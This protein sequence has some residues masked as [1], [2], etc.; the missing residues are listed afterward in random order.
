MDQEQKEVN[1]VEPIENLCG[2]CKKPKTGDTPDKLCQ[3][4]RPTNDELWRQAI[5]A[6]VTKLTPETVNK[7]KE[8]FAI[9]C[10]IEQACKYAEISKQTYYNWINANPELLDEFEEMKE[11]LPLKAKHNIALKIHAGDVPLSERYLSRKEPDTYADRLKIEHSGEIKGDKT[12]AQ[13]VEARKK[14]QE[15]AKSIIDK[16]WDEDS[17]P[18]TPELGTDTK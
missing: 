4:G 3:C 14:W 9:D 8:A 18:I 7:L 6:K 16:S 13:L 10:T 1:K 12:Y 15:E 5:G 17:Q 11:T 2:N